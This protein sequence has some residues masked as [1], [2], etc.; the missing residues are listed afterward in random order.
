MGSRPRLLLLMHRCEP[1][2]DHF[3]EERNTTGDLL[4]AIRFLVF[5]E[6]TPADEFS[7]TSNI[8][9]EQNGIVQEQ[10][11]TFI[12]EHPGLRFVVPRT[13]RKYRV[14][15]RASAIGGAAEKALGDVVMF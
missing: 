10:F 9:G 8:L 4:E 14:S 1:A 6:S 15:L 13:A 2:S 3:V 7:E 11:M 5:R 12:A